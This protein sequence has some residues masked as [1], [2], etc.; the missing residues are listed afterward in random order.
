MDCC[1]TNNTTHRNPAIHHLVYHATLVVPGDDTRH[2]IYVESVTSNPPGGF[3]FHFNG[4]P[5]A[6]PHELP[7]Q[8]YPAPDGGSSLRGVL[9]V[10]SDNHLKKAVCRRPSIRR[11]LRRVDWYGHL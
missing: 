11:Q 2:P 4:I 1:D 9:W 10:F 5:S 8:T 6:D 7:S 3:L